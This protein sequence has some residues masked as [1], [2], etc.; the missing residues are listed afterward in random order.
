MW[1]FCRYSIKATGIFGKY[2]DGERERVPYEGDTYINQLGHFCCAADYSMAKATIE[3]FFEYWTWP[4][5]WVLIT[6]VLARDYMLYSGDCE[7]V[8]KWVPELEKK[9]DANK[10]SVQRRL[11]LTQKLTELEALR[12]TVNTLQQVL[13]TIPPEII[14]TYAIENSVR[15]ET[16]TI[17]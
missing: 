2:V 1:D 8:K 6:P 15:K 7:T 13:H 4:M 16:H 9:L 11:E 5:E 10:E 12:S 3:Y 17:E 14:E